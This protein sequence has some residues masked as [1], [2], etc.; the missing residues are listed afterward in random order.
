VKLMVCM[1]V[2][3]VSWSNTGR[4]SARL[5]VYGVLLTLVLCSDTIKI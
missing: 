2:Q 5:S 3:E 4:Y 1:M